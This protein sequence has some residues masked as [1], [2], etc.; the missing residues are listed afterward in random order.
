MFHIET[1]KKT[2]RAID[3]RNNLAGL[4]V[5]LYNVFQKKIPVCQSGLATGIEYSKI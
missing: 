2:R 3:M 4:I 5:K 1:K